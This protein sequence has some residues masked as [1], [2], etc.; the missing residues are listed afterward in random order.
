MGRATAAVV[1]AGTIPVG[2]LEVATTAAEEDRVTT[3]ATEETV[4]VII[5]AVAVAG[6]GAREVSGPSE[7]TLVDE[8][9]PVPTARELLAVG[10][11]TTAPDRSR[12]MP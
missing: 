7:T 1:A 9:L 5:V 4:E 11:T 6:T 2:I 10:A 3:A 8:A 12:P